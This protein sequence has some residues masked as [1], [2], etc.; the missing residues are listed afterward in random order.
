MRKH[1][2]DQN[3]RNREL[4][5][6]YQ[7][8]KRDMPW[9]RK[10][11]LY[12]TLLSEFMLQQTRADQAIPYF[13]RFL[14]AFPNMKRLA[15][16]PLQQVL[17]L[18]EGLGYYSRARNLHE[19]AKR[20]AGKRSVTTELLSDC[21]GI[22]PYT[23]A[24]I[25]SISLNEPLP[26]VD[27]NVNRVVSRILALDE[28]P[29]SREGKDRILKTVQSW[30]ERGSPGDWNQ[31]MMELGATVCMPRNPKCPACPWSQRCEANRLGSQ[32]DF[33]KRREKAPVPHRVHAAAVIRRKN[34][35]ILIAQRPTTGLLANL[36]EFPGGECNSGEN[37]KACAARVVNEKLAVR[38]KIGR[39]LDTIKHAFSHF[40]LT[41]NVF[42]ATLVGGRKRNAAYQD[43]KWVKPS[44]LRVYPFPRAHWPILDK[45]SPDNE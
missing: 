36:W 6:W 33:P 40:S 13:H 10:P 35:D 27:G 32:E 39:K 43:S 4:L 30:I 44:R 23:L 24:A 1:H 3:N 25:A 29:S 20:L 16:A 42:E 34:R 11:S 22:G 18:W 38:I 12:R 45:L 37:L 9:R 28:L 41:L 8:N 31:A 15:E 19:T 17:K 7:E 21:P 26:V 2:K 14:K 5:A